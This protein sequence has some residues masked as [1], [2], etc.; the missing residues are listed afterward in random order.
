GEFL[1]GLRVVRAV[2]FDPAISQQFRSFQEKA[3]LILPENELCR[4]AEAGF[5]E[6]C[7]ESL[8]NEVQNVCLRL[9]ESSLGRFSRRV[10]CGM[11]GILSWALIW[12]Q[13]GSVCQL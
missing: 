7:H 1:V 5:G 4:L 8:D 9:E 3:V 6:G 12:S 13:G 10:D 2:E 11:G